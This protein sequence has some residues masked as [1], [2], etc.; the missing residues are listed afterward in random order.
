METPPAHPEARPEPSIRGRGAARNPPNRFLPLVVER[1]AW[2][3]AEDTAPGTELLEDRSRSVIARNV[4][5]DVG[6]DA[7]LNPYRGCEHG[8]AYCYAR[9]THEYLGFSAGL[10]FETKILVKSK[11][12]ELLRQELASPRWEPQ[13]LAL[14]GVTDP[15]QPAERRL[16]LTR[17]CLEVLVE[18]RNPV[19]VITKN[20]LVTRDA[21]LL[22]ELARH[23]AAAVGVS[24]TTLDRSLQR[25][26]EP[27]T[28]TPERRLA[29]IARLAE[30]G[31]PV[32]VMV[33]PVIPGLTDHEIPAILEAAAAAG[34]QRAAY[35]MLR[36]PLA[37]G[38][39]FEDWM[40]RH[41]PDRV[42]KVMNRMRDLHGGRV[43][44]PGF[45]TRM[46]GSGPYA[47]EV[48]RLFALSARRFGLTRRSSSLSAAAFRRPSLGP[49]L[50]LFD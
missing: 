20:H 37:V 47:D 46:R 9:P 16:R 13:V 45:E 36:L 19:M 11:A 29:A 32:R 41:V 2:T 25:R 18:A 10:D 22:G 12:P 6:F 17:R 24:I 8:C 44:D 28:S 31:I 3:E 26:L 42:A 40:T 38:P 43:Y 27:R 35:I 1:E 21:D 39:L 7:S 5:P 48:G 33:A 23:D 50:G 30:A 14:S 49:Q 34:A 15:Y 4:S